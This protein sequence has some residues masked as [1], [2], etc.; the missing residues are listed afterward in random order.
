MLSKLVKAKRRRQK[1]LYDR[2]NG[3]IL[4]QVLW[5]DGFGECPWSYPEFKAKVQEII[6]D[7]HN[8]Y[9]SQQARNLMD[10]SSEDCLRRAQSRP[11]ERDK[12]LFPPVEIRVA[13]DQWFSA[14]ISGDRTEKAMLIRQGL[15]DQAASD[16]V[17]EAI[18]KS[19]FIENE[20]WSPDYTDQQL[21][22]MNRSTVD[23]DF[24]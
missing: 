2:I 20:A 17:N 1:P 11:K 14:S 8:L 7:C 24:D 4:G 22:R 6:R 18:A 5:Y 3:R 23:A 21:S 10:L 19:L 13:E 9:W 12:L 16:E 15:R